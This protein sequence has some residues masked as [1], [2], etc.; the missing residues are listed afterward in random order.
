M[1][2][3]IF[4]YPSTCIYCTHLV[5]VY[6]SVC[7]FCERA[8]VH[9]ICFGVYAN[10]GVPFAAANHIS[11]LHLPDSIFWKL[12]DCISYHKMFVVLVNITRVSSKSW[13]YRH[14][15]DV[16]KDL[17]HAIRRRYVSCL[18]LVKIL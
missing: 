12:C 10:C 3:T 7:I 15:V 9:S 13:N 4:C 17:M 18:I 8:P 2:F 16:S 6:L 11:V 1:Y 14:F 5:G